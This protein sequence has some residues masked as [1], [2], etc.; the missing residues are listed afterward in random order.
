LESAY[1]ELGLDMDDDS[2]SLNDIFFLRYDVS[3]NGK[4]VDISL[5]NEE[6]TALLDDLTTKDDYIKNIRFKSIDDDEFEVSFEIDDIDK[7]IDELEDKITDISEYE[8]I[9]DL[10]ENIME[11]KIMY[12]TGTLEF[13]EEDGFSSDYGKLKVGILPIPEEQ[14][15]LAVDALCEYMNVIVDDIGSFDITSFEITED[16]LDFVGIIPEDIDMK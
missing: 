14:G 5:S 9:I 8:N 7:A 13:D 16:G 15:D 3:D 4:A 6:I 12:Y 10:A 1:E 11:D 2:P